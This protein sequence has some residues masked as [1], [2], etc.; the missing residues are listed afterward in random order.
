MKK[1]AIFN[2]KGGV[3]KTTTAISLSYA[4]S[5]N[6]FK[7]LLIDLDP[8]AN[9][10]LGLGVQEDATRSIYSVLMVLR[11]TQAARCR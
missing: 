8:Q 3:G 2:Q 1:I 9:A 6:G 10:T 7:V 4:F 11:Q 5:Q